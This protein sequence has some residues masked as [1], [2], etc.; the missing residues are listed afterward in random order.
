MAHRAGGVFLFEEA[1]VHELWRNEFFLYG[2]PHG[3]AAV[4]ALWRMMPRCST[5]V[6]IAARRHTAHRR[7]GEKK[8]R[9][10]INRLLQSSSPDG[11][12]W[13]EGEHLYLQLID[14]ARRRRWSTLVLDNDRD[15]AQDESV[16]TLTAALTRAVGAIGASTPRRTERRGR[17]PR[18]R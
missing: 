3:G 11:P 15:E 17:S 12:V 6:H 9:G 1:T 7:I 16:L 13:V 18:S 4:A 10:P 2:T 5:V 14:R 8:K